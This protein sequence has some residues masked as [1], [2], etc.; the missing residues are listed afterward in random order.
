MQRR[1]DG[2]LTQIKTDPIPAPQPSRDDLQHALENVHARMGGI[3]ESAMD[4]IITIDEQQRI[5]QF[6]AAAER[7]FLWPR[8][9]VIGQGLDVLIPER[10]R[11]RH[12]EHIERFGSTAVTSRGMG[13][14]TVLYGMRANGE[15]FPIEASISQLVESGKKL[16]TVILRD[17]SQRMRDESALAR[18]EARLRAILDSA[19]DAIITVDER[20]HIVLFNT[21][22]EVVFR[23]PRDE[24]IGASLSWCIPNRFRAAH[25]AH[26]RKFGVDQ[27]ASRRM[28][29]ARL[30][31]GLR[32]D[33][34]EFPIEASISY[35]SEEERRFYTVILRDVTARVKS[36]EA[37]R[38]SQEEIQ[39]LALAANQAREEEK[40]RIA[41]ELH[42]ELGQSLTALKMDVG[43]LRQS[44]GG[45]DE[46][47]TRKLDSMQQLLDS[48]VAA[49]RRISSDLRPMM[50]DDLGLTAAADWLV[51]NFTSHTGVPCE[52]VF[53]ADADLDLADPHGTAIFRV[54]QESLT[55]VA[56]HAAATQVE[57]TLERTGNQVI[58]SVRDNGSGIAPGSMNKQG[59]FGLTGQRERA[60]L[61]GGNL[62]IDS[63]PGE[64]TLVEFRIPLPATQPAP[65]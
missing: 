19:M 47:I 59:S 64:G 61:L 16:F 23:C 65:T 30:V 42:D 5:V 41:R 44:L 33:G 8:A 7:V 12:K 9:A 49:A 2:S 43:A 13:A 39:S 14:R 37:L 52:L 36:D 20:Q 6:N 60:Y 21:A 63:A 31:M 38:R 15:E 45:A 25:A 32:R 34:E 22:A 3:V 28:G 4:A 48:T 29:A 10:F 51:Q 17:V 50:L 11:E 40:R 62:R 26:I 56:R 18:S 1:D 35:T 57:V 55:N 58:L 46:T 54:L 24:A 27:D 53:S